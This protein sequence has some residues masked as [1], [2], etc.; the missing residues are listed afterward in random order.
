MNDLPLEKQFVHSTFCR[1]LEEIE[2]EAAKKLLAD[3]H[4]LYLG[5]Q[6]LFAKMIKQGNVGMDKIDFEG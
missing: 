3:L 1:Q 5:Q 4:L 2:L 6:A